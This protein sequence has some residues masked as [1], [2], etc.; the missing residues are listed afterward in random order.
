MIREITTD[1]KALLV[2]IRKGLG[3]SNSCEELL[4]DNVNWENI[5]KLSRKQGVVG[6]VYDGVSLLPK[7]T[8]TERSIIPKIAGS[9]NKYEKKYEQKIWATKKLVDEWNH[10]GIHIFLLKG[11]S[12]GRYYPNP[13]RRYSSDVDVYLKEHCKGIMGLDVQC[14]K[15]DGNAWERG[16]RI[17][18]KMGLRVEEE[19]QKHTLIYT[20]G[21]MIENHRYFCSLMG[22]SK[23][24]RLNK[25]LQKLLDEDPTI[26]L[27]DTKYEYPSLIFD[28]LF[29]IY[30][31][32]T[33]FLNGE[34]FRLSHVIDWVLIRNNIIERGLTNRLVKLCEDYG[35]SKFY[36]SLDGIAS[37]IEGKVDLNIMTEPQLLMFQEILN[38]SYKKKEQS[39]KD[40]WKIR[41]EHLV[42]AFRDRWK[43]SL[44]TDTS[45]IKIMYVSIIGYFRRIKT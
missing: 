5:V 40:I 27:S 12:F 3:L 15:E 42:T 22:D 24:R 25:C 9:T 36:I 33:H 13:K 23:I 7:G 38:G 32:R 41:Y 43:Y 14:I 45:F 4:P 6:I 28:A 39:D 34:D 2:L 18:K 20:D 31:A 26:M 11:M 16:N 37:Y 29:C 10:V 21:V 8:I 44:Y 30:H 35:L 17:A 19:I 1:E